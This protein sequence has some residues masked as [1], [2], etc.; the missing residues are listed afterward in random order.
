MWPWL[1]P[2]CTRMNAPWLAQCYCGP[3]PAPI[4]EPPT[5]L[6]QPMRVVDGE[7]KPD[8]SFILTMQD[9]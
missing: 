1:C 6:P 7:R 5:A 2:R 9:D 4:T 8:G 3:I